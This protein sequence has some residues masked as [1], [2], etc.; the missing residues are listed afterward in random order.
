MVLEWIAEQIKDMPNIV[1]LQL[2][3]EPYPDTAEVINPWCK[4][5]GSFIVP[6]LFGLLPSTHTD[7]STMNRLKPILGN[8]FP[9]YVFG[10]NGNRA[11]WVK[12]Q[13]NFVVMDF[14]L[15]RITVEVLR[16][17]G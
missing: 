14:H 10:N 4:S 15:V 1:G 13:T 17:G 3:N 8:D 6:L 7:E 16:E 12:N 2:L 9:F 5:Y 11:E